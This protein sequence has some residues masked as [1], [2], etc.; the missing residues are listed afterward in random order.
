MRLLL[1]DIILFAISTSAV[2]CSTNVT[3][4]D[5]SRTKYGDIKFYSEKISKNNSSVKRIYASVKIG[6]NESYYSFYPDK[7]V[8][9]TDTA[10]TLIYTVSYG[11]LQ[12][13]NDRNIYQKFSLLDSMILTKGDNLLDSLGF[14]NFRTSIGAKGFQTEV[15][16]YHGFPKNKKF[17]P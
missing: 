2:A 1:R 3:L 6:D 11:Q 5:K 13:S 8:K 17:R 15:N 16:Y 14:H 10:K 9:T 7:I 12:T 4:I